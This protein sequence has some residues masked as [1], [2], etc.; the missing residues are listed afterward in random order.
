M[1]RRLFLAGTA[2]GV[3]ALTLPALA[4]PSNPA[5]MLHRE[6][7]KRGAKFERPVRQDAGDL[8]MY[9]ADDIR[10]F[11]MDEAVVHL[12]DK[13]F[14][15]Y[16]FERQ[17]WSFQFKSGRFERWGDSDKDRG[18]TYHYKNVVVNVFEFRAANTNDMV[19]VLRCGLI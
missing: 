8:E 6:L 19:T 9:A 12:A 11:V 18:A 13:L 1:N 15:L 7:V 16:R 14:E 4:D 17:N 2:A 3:G 10:R 5:F